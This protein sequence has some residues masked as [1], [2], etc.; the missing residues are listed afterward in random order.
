MSD[1]KGSVFNLKQ[2]VSAAITPFTND[3]KLDLES[4][5]RL[6][7][8]GLRHGIDGFF[9][10]GSMGE[11]A[12][13]T[14][15]ER[16]ELSEVACDVIGS[17]AKVLLGISDT[18]LPSILANMERLSDLKHSHWVIVP[19]GGWAGPGNPVSYAH[20]IADAADRP[21]YFYYI[22]GFNNIVL[23]VD[24]FREIL[25]HPR[26]AGIK[27]SAGGIR[28]RKELLI[29]RQTVDFELYEGEE[30]GI[31]ES[32][33]MGCDGAIAGFASVAGKLM[34]NIAREVDR[35]DLKTACDLQFRVIDMFHKVY[36]DS[37]QWWSAGQKYAL[38]Y[39]GIISSET[40]RVDAQQDMPESHRAQIRACIDANRD[41]LE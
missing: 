40:S 34:K 14:A 17:K 12:L 4:A 30:W 29:L 19:P 11:W 20:R 35:A 7:E 21:L 13:L 28:I 18:G 1:Q 33:A 37:A 5:A 41:Y 27:N 2:I 9:I 24:Q 10:C 38:K 36:G 31:D 39:M 22:P 25:A 15:R 16:R 6:Y 26:I 3:N 32:L 23:T 8:A